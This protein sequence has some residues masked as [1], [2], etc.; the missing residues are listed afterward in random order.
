M[1]FKNL[2]EIADV[3]RKA[4]GL[5]ADQ[6]TNDPG[7]GIAVTDDGKLQVKANTS[8]GI[9]VDADGVAIQAD[10]NGFK[11]ADG[12]L[13]LKK[14]AGWDFAPNGDIDIQ[15]DDNGGI[16]CAREVGSKL[17]IKTGSGIKLDG[18]VA[19]NYGRGLR[20]TNG[21]LEAHPG[22]GLTTDTDDR[23]LCVRVKDGVKIDGDHLTVKAA[24][25]GAIN[26]DSGGVWV[27]AKDKGGLVIDGDN[28]LA[29]NYGRGLQITDGKLTSL[30]GAALSTD[31]DGKLY[32]E[33][34][35]GVKIDGDHLTVNAN[36]NHGINVDGNGVAVKNGA[37]LT[38]GGT[39]NL[40]VV[41]DDNGG[42][43]CDRV[44]GSGLSVK[45]GHGI[46]V[47]GSG[48]AVCL[49]DNVFIKELA[50][51]IIPRGT[52]VPFFNEDADIPDGWALCDGN[53]S[54]PNLCNGVHAEWTLVMGVNT[55][56][57]VPRADWHL[58]N[59][60]CTIGVVGIRYIMK[61]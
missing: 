24:E 37:G 3:G 49:T 42:I 43:K 61:L 4:V 58:G 34:K 27:K 44:V 9:Q 14:G 40:D 17:S 57:P 15:V 22:D 7:N 32:V 41:V 38:F 53:S 47:D 45:A 23:N 1:D 5:S 36:N 8:A 30:P 54:T 16:L 11:F 18:G 56:K 20:I 39:G 52:V 31:T 29:V 55:K 2:I 10:V 6:S 35:D 60:D 12:K 25:S 21:A 33:V 51:L 59:G 26:V 50:K 19:V 48:V 28:G 46:K 13:S